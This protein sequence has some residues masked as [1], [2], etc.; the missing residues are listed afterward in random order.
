MSCCLRTR[1]FR[2]LHK[3]TSA[4][5][6]VT[7][8]LTSR[9]TQRARLQVV[10]VL[11]YIYKFIYF[12]WRLITILYWFCHTSPWIRHGCTHVPHPETPPTSLPIPS[13]WV[14]PVH[15]PWA[16]CIMLRT[17][18]GNS[19]LIWYYTCFNAILPNPYMATGKTV[20]LTRQTFVGKVMSMHFNML[21]RLFINF[22][23]RSKHLFIPWLQSPSTVILEPPK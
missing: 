13:L 10:K 1:S 2:S 5:S 16:F 11:F 12:N 4:S 20:A 6:T 8:A 22:L 14:I 17:W 15:Q 23:P 9:W 3:S 21:S 19:F 18:T 7:P